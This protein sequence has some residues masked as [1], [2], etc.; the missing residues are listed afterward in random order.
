MET[1]KTNEVHENMP[2]GK[3][4]QTVLHERYED[5]V[6]VKVE[7]KLFLCLTKHYAVKTYGGGGGGRYVDPRFLDCGTS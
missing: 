1:E 4:R 6:E 2:A 5:S 7:G 3:F